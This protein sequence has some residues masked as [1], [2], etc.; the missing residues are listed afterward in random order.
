[1]RSFTVV[2]RPD[3]S[4][5]LVGGHSE[6]RRGGDRATARDL[7]ERPIIPASALRGA[8]RIELERLLRG[9]DPKSTACSA[10]RP[11]PAAGLEPCRC[12]VCRLFG[13]E[14]STTGSLRLEDALLPAEVAPPEADL[15][16]GVGV[17]RRTRT[18]VAKHL[19][20]AE[21]S[22]VLNA[23]G[24]RMA[25]RAAA[26]LVPRGTQDDAT[27]L[28]EDWRNLA[29]A[30]A[31]LNGLGGGKARGL[32]WVQCSLDP[33]NLPS[34][35]G[36]AGA[37]DELPAESAA[38]LPSGTASVRLRFEALAP[39]HLGQG[40]PIAFFQR[41][42]RHAPG[43]TVRGALAFALLEHGLAR[44]GDA[45]LAALFSP[46][47][48]ASFG[49][50]RTA[51]DVPSATRRRCRAQGHVFD[52]LVGELVRR[53][54][55]AKGLA[56]A[57]SGQGV[58]I[59]PGCKASK[60]VAEPRR[61]GTRGPVVRVRT[62]TA[63]NR[64]TGTAMDRKLYSLEALEPSVPRP[65]V[66][67]SYD[68]LV[69]EAEVHGLPAETLSLLAS[70]DGREAWLGAKRSRGMGRCRVTLQPCSEEDAAA[71]RGR[72]EALGVA[73]EEAWSAVQRT[74]GE[75]LQDPFL[76]PDRVPLAIVLQEPWA[77]AADGPDLTQ[78]PLAE[79]GTELIDAFLSTSEEG[80]FGANEASWYGAP[81]HVRRGEEP[82]VRTAAAGSVYVY[83]VAR[84][85]LEARLGDW[86]A[87]G[88][89][90]S[91]L[92]GEIGWG[93]FVIRGPEVDF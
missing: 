47:S 43:S 89:A 70:L 79:H 22:G 77:P 11:E 83:S 31:A 59:Q 18:V 51:G 69:L 28:A 81:E 84:G 4:A 20:F 33:P 71:A 19:T 72:I 14:G 58:C 34:A 88:R 90:G 76:A 80:R 32:G 49:A 68:P 23:G 60:L 24:R 44:D 82:P 15:R 53:A 26:R 78:G 65:G 13:A 64:L 66:S 56:L 52:D 48:G 2:V 5:L 3:A 92:H 6:G 93:R 30:C 87:R 54:A 21:T 40:R 55:A 63:L 29:L 91:G 46:S 74:A 41:S 17:G 25:F 8:L 86:L 27:S 9:L 67:G 42:L 36:S 1:M 16:P 38:P 35:A 39:L 85:E 50:A 37:A 75:R 45:A 7:E 62:R 61:D 10:N 73:L 57:V 12:P